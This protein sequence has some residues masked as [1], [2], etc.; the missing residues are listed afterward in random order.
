MRNT[1]AGAV[2]VVDLEA[3]ED[4]EADLVRLVVV[5]DA[6]LARL[7]LDM[8][9]YQWLVRGGG[10]AEI[11]EIDGIN[12]RRDGAHGRGGIMMPMGLLGFTEYF[13]LTGLGPGINGDRIG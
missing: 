2:G 4:F 7:E 9:Q 6:D 5:L 12:I 1:E 8:L 3:V 10:V 11:G 13:L